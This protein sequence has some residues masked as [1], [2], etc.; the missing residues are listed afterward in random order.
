MEYKLNKCPSCGEDKGVRS[1]KL[2]QT[3]KLNH[4]VLCLSCGY[5]T[6]LK[7][8]KELAVEF[9][10]SY[11]QTIDWSTA[12]SWANYCGRDTNGR[13]IW[14][15]EM[16]S[17]S[18]N[19]KGYKYYYSLSQQ[20]NNNCYSLRLW[21]RPKGTI[22]DAITLLEKLTGDYGDTVDLVLNILKENST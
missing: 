20:S 8:T 17:L 10:N 3:R 9:W 18:E 12:P 14:F 2:R 16:P 6:G 13:T 7:K 15:A 4:C 22:E 21:A 19:G 5:N 1:S 11:E